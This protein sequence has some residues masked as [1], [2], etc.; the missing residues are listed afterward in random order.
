MLENIVNFF[1]SRLASVKISPRI[2]IDYTSWDDEIKLALKEQWE[3]L[4]EELKLHQNIIKEQKW[5]DGYSDGRRREDIV[6]E[7]DG[8][9]MR[10]EGPYYPD[11]NYNRPPIIIKTEEQQGNESID[12]LITGTSMVQAITHCTELKFKT[13]ID[14]LKATRT[15]NKNP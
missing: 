11:P 15:A 6:L 2:S 5:S 10:L 13:F 12:H 14:F 3:K 8:V 9:V 7:I 1:K 4:K